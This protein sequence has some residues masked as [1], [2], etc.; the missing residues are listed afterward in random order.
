MP[1]ADA[2]FEGGGVQGIGLVGALQE[3]EAAGWGWRMVAGTSAGALVAALVA[4]G[5]RATELRDILEVLDYREFKDEGFIDRVPIIGQVASLLFE[6]GVY[7]GDYFENWIRQLL[8]R[9]GVKT[10]ADLRSNFPHALYAHRLQVLV[11]D[12]TES[13]IL[14]LPSGLEHYRISADDYDVA[15][16]VRMSISIP[17]L[18]EPVKDRGHYFV[19][20]GLLSNFPVW[21]FDRQPEE[22]D[23]ADRPP[24]CPTFG[25]KLVGPDEG[26]PNEIDSL[27]DYIKALVITMLESHDKQ[28]LEDADFLRTIAIPTVGVRIT[29][30][31]ITPERRNRL[32][33]SGRSAAREFLR[34]GNEDASLRRARA[35]ASPEERKERRQYRERIAR[36]TARMIGSR[37]Y[38]NP[39]D[40][41]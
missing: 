10:F 12:I 35:P 29:E 8:G 13:R 40:V 14:V 31:S 3:M 26:A 17:F 25:F 33:E 21:L 6:K 20:G 34:T 19:D 9:K 18:C 16:A 28:D 30:F 4:A 24:R 11:S 38:S 41:G 15:R 36:R 23:A 7:E 32:Y 22:P 1:M 5:Y 2:V 39:P 27:F 37:A